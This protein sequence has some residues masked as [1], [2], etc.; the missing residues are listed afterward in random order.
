MPLMV[1]GKY[2]GQWPQSI[3]VNGTLPN[4]KRE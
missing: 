3:T 4:G 1:A 2:D